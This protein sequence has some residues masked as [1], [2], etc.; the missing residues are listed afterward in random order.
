MRYDGQGHEI[1]VP[2]PARRLTAADAKKLRAEYEKRYEAQFGLRIAD[3]PV[4]FLTWS[5][6]VS[7]VAAG[8]S[9]SVTVKTEKNNSNFQRD[10]QAC[11]IRVRGK[12][13]K[14]PSY[15]RGELAP[16]ARL[17]GP[18]LV[19]EPQTTTLVPRGWRCSVTGA[20][21]LL[22]ETPRMKGMKQQLVTQILWNRLIAVVEEQANV[23]LK[24]AF[25]TITREAG[26]LS[27]GVYDTKGRMLAQAVT[28]TPGHVNTMATAVAHFLERFPAQHAASPATCWSPTTRGWAPGTCSTS[29]PSRRPS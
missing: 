27:A 2:L 21:D 9:R 19:V 5:V 28:G 20:G 23:L 12:L 24:T 26:D 7:T 11:S 22:L 17:A 25:G 15:R 16:G 4:E 10:E 13:E 18:A 1:S 29:S 6:G 8:S 3:V 14:I